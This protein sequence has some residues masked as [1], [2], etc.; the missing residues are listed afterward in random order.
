MYRKK[1]LTVIGICLLLLCT[2]TTYNT[3]A[4]GGNIE[5]TGSSYYDALG[6]S[7]ALQLNDEASFYTIV[8]TYCGINYQDP[9]DADLIKRT[10]SNTGNTILLKYCEAFDQKK[11]NGASIM[12]FSFDGLAAGIIPNRGGGGRSGISFA[13]V[14]DG[15]SR[16]IV[17]RVK[18]EALYSFLN[19]FYEDMESWEEMRILFPATYTHI[20]VLKQQDN[21][22]IDVMRNAFRQDMNNLSNNVPKLAYT[23]NYQR[24]M[25]KYPKLRTTFSVA[26]GLGYLIENR[27]HPAK[28]IDKMA[29]LSY[30]QNSDN[31]N[32]KRAINTLTFVS[33]SLRDTTTKA[34]WISAEQLT[35]LET[36]PAAPMLFV[37][38]NIQNYGALVDQLTINPATLNINT[39][40]HL[41]LP[42][43]QTRRG[44]AT[45]Q[46][47]NMQG[48]LDAYTLNYDPLTYMPTADSTS[49]A[50]YNMFRPYYQ[51][52]LRVTQ[53]INEDIDHVKEKRANGLNTT[54]EDYLRYTDTFLDVLGMALSN[55]TFGAGEE[56]HSVFLT[57]APALLNMRQAIVNEQ[58]SSAIVFLSSMLLSALPN[59]FEAKDKLLEY[60]LFMGNVA[61]A[62][63]AAGV[64]LALEA[65]A[66]PVGSSSVKKKSNFN[67]A[68]NAY[69]G[70]FIGQEFLYEQSA[71]ATSGGLSAPIGIAFSHGMNEL[72]SI[73]F[74]MSII[75]LGALVSFRF[76]DPFSSD[77]P[78]F[79]LQNIIAPGGYIIYG[80]PRLPISVGAGLQYGPQLRKVRIGNA[81]INSSAYRVGLFIGV[82]IPVFNLYNRPY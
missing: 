52:F 24:F 7:S 71:W 54:T 75:D 5:P 81:D 23:T 45:N 2:S 77:L 4:Q 64:Q 36:Q 3:Y 11:R 22:A 14:A 79:K 78:E 67:I 53:H 32:V 41:A 38:L 76:R 68:L 35:Y 56:Q 48:I 26:A 25:Q 28:V 39:D 57:V 13:S 42:Y 62:Q 60:G 21:P 73:S 61:S 63:T 51:D 31:Q 44:G 43:N 18:Q 9:S 30:I 27:E 70:P 58:Y 66:M 34:T 47:I 16:F 15:F 80:V 59:D 37:G 19:R 65:F 17:G 72:G 33:N 8:G 55:V 12:G 6:L 74:L 10:L 49:Y 46:Q 29:S 50:L 82:D 40:K 69:A 20:R 1:T